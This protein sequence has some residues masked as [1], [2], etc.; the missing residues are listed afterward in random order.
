MYRK[1]TVKDLAGLLA[2]MQRKTKLKAA[3]ARAELA[4][5]AKQPEK[6]SISP[7][8]AGNADSTYVL[9]ETRLLVHTADGWVGLPYLWNADQTEAYYMP[10]GGLYE[11]TYLHQVDAAPREFN[12]NYA[13]PDQN[14]CAS[15]H[16]TKDGG[17]SGQDIIPIGIQVRHIN[18]TMIYLKDTGI[19]QL[20]EWYKQGIL[21]NLAPA[22]SR[23]AN[24]NYQDRSARLE[25]RAHAYLDANCAHCHRAEGPARTSGLRLPVFETD[26]TARG[27]CKT[28]VAAGRGSGGYDFDLNPG[29]PQ[30]SILMFRMLSEDPGIMMPELG[31]S[32]VHVE[33]IALM[34]QWIGAMPGKCK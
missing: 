26:L 18:K 31:R 12:L 30:E 9:L 1:D 5:I 28:P 10:A 25:D 22:K 32:V 17:Q 3:R 6:K 20:E 2:R 15:C 23:P 8:Q 19:N 13:I 21:I 4:P 27:R 7:Y 24:V 29:K 33:S 34:R 11:F 16:I 14:Q